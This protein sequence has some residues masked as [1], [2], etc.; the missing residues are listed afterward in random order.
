MR[1]SVTCIDRHAIDTR[2]DLHAIEAIDFR[3]DHHAINA[4]DFRTALHG[5]LGRLLAFGRRR[6]RRLV[7]VRVFLL[8]RRGFAVVRNLLQPSSFLRLLLLRGGLFHFSPFSLDCLIFSLLLVGSIVVLHDVASLVRFL[9]VES[10][11]LVV[12]RRFED[13]DKILLG[14]A[15]CEISTG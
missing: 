10:E 15:T 1:P 3:V 8:V 2:V 13:I 6:R 11:G 5:F 4:I 14:H 9:C 12:G 7:T